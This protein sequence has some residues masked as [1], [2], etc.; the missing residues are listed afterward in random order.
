[1]TTKILTTIT[2][3]MV[4]IILLLSCG[5]L[6]VKTRTTP[7]HEPTATDVYDLA[8]DWS[9]SRNPNGV[10]GLYKAPQKLFTTN[11]HDWFSNGTHQNAWADAP[12][13]QLTHVPMW[14][15]INDTLG[16]LFINDREQYTNFVDKGYIIMHGAESDRSGTEYSRVI[17]TSPI[18]GTIKIVGGLWMAKEYNRPMIWEIRKNSVVLSTGE[19][20]QGDPYSINNPCEYAYGSGG[21]MALVQPVEIHDEI[22]LMIY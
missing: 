10:W 14:M 11:Q 20:S 19:L 15:K 16:N 8:N 3:M 21:S 22:E 17:W 1:M 9:D 6:P 18:Q 2:F 13:P 12:Y 4:C 5:Y 7:D